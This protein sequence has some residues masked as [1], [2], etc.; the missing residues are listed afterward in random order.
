[1]IV[2]SFLKPKSL[3][4]QFQRGLETSSLFYPTKNAKETS[5][6]CPKLIQKSDAQPPPDI[7]FTLVAPGGPKCPLFLQNESKN[8]RKMEPKCTQD[9]IKMTPKSTISPLWPQAAQSAPYSSKTN[10]KMIET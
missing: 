4:N 9:G 10:P 5:K 7:I 3:K 6:P 1:M 2:G 8:D